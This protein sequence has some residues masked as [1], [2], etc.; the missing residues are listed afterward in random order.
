MCQISTP[1]APITPIEPKFQAL[2]SRSIS[3]C[4]EN[5]IAARS[6]RQVT[7]PSVPSASGSSSIA[8][9]ASHNANRRPLSIA[10]EVLAVLTS[11]LLRA[12]CWSGT[13]VP[14]AR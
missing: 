1:V 6:S 14:A 13:A 7:G 12:G 2:P 4:A 5:G 11:S 10:T 3:G 8:E 9:P